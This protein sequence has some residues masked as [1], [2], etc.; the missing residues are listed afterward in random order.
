MTKRS[1]ST[2]I[3][4]VTAIVGIVCGISFL[5]WPISVEPTAG[6]PTAL[7]TDCGNAIQQGQVYGVL[8][9]TDDAPLQFMS[10]SQYQSIEDCNDFRLRN[11]L[12]G[13]GALVASASIVIAGLA[14]S[15][16][17]GRRHNT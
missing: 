7:A 2:L 9:H 16:R 5:F 17:A 3:G 11:R 4:A 6:Q 1:P 10:R 13:A 15:R 12:V 8:R 14:L